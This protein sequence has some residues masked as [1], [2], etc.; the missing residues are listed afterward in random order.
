MCMNRNMY[1]AA[2]AWH[3]AQVKGHVEY[4]GRR[5]DEPQLSG[6]WDAALKA[7]YKGGVEQLLWAKSPPHEHPSRCMRNSSVCMHVSDFWRRNVGLNGG[8]MV[9]LLKC[10]AIW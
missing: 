9:R 2:V 5:L 4:D 8:S 6:K 10:Y 3:A 1:K 7:V